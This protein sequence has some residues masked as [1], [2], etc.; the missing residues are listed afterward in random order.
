MDVSERRACEAISQPRMT[1]RYKAKQPDKDKALTAEINKLAK[2]YKR[3]G[4]RMITAKLRQSGWI[5]NHKRIQRI[6]Q[7]E[8]LQVSYRR[9][10]RKAKGT[11]DNSCAVKKAEYPNHVWTYDFISDQTEDGGKLKILTVLDEFTRESPAIEL[12]RSIRAGDVIGILEYLFKVRGAPKFIRSDNGP[13][14]IADAIEKWLKNYHVETL[15]IAPGS[16]WENGYIE[17]FNGKLRDDVLNREV[18]HSVKEAKV[19]VENWRLEYNNH[20]PHSSL[21]Y[22]TPA[23]FAASRNPPGSA[24]LRLPDCG[25]KNVDNSLIEVGT[26]FG[27][28][29]ERIGVTWWSKG[30]KR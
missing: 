28:R 22:M 7:K 2:R 21:G 13:E 25:I 8:G 1:Q 23:A 16:P 12:G 30:P 5:V 6:W 17:S 4:Y 29:P 24:T 10:F 3:Y 20:R 15:H 18:F 11:S 9:K 27:V 14:F 26:S 19:I